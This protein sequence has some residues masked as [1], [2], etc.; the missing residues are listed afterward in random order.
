M[1]KRYFLC[2]ACLCCC[3]GMAAQNSWEIREKHNNQVYVN[4]DFMNIHMGD[5]KINPQ[6]A[7]VGVG[8]TW[9]LGL[10]GLYVDGG[11]ELGYHQGKADYQYR[12]NPY[13]LTFKILDGRV[14]LNVGFKFPVG[15]DMN[16]R[17]YAG[18]NVQY[19]FSEKEN[20][21]NFNGPVDT[22][23]EYIQNSFRYGLQAG[24]LLDFTDRWFGGAEFSY[25]LN[26]IQDE[27]QLLG[28]AATRSISDAH[29]VSHIAYEA[30]PY[31]ITLR[32][33]YRF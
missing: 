8:H 4:V 28:T 1:L 5:L 25:D 3:M 30:H 7:R 29:V 20:C 12:E 24:V 32:L 11:V 23:P 13:R 21:H 19:Y 18:A 14:P 22:D 17:V 9:E 27:E 2:L 26:P 6:G 31:A 33:G 15:Q 16:L 10:Q